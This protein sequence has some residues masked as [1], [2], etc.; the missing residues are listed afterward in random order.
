MASLE[1]HKS[2][3]KLTGSWLTWSRKKSAERVRSVWHSTTGQGHFWDV[4]AWT[5]ARPG[6]DRKVPNRS[7]NA[8][9]TCMG[10]YEK[11]KILFGE[12]T[13]REVWRWKNKKHFWICFSKNS[14]RTEKHKQS[15]F[16]FYFSPD[17]YS[18]QQGKAR[19]I[20]IINPHP[21][22]HFGN[23]LGV[24]CPTIMT[25]RTLYYHIYKSHWVTSAKA[26]I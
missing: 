5:G 12:P 14:T 4:K 3:V 25:E 7:W 19:R 13:G 22:C 15:F 24:S 10:K 6:Q 21:L 16:R 17:F 2:A 11:R 20:R 26:T 9:A 18:S 23:K 8:R 1:A